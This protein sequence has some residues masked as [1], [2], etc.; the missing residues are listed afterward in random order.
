VAVE[1]KRVL[2]LEPE[3]GVLAREAILEERVGEV[4]ERV[5]EVSDELRTLREELESRLSITAGLS[6]RIDNLEA[7]KRAAEMVGIWK[8]QTCI[9]QVNGICTLWRLSREA[10]DQLGMDII[11]EDPEEKGVY[12][13]KV[14]AAPWFCALCPLY[15]RKVK[16]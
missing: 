8:L 16:L 4:E 6:S 15:Q 7:F 11:V 10:A 5:K 12:R 1:A 2:P 14:S 9:Y 3:P 13:V